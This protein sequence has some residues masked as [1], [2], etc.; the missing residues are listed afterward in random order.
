MNRYQFNYK[1]LEDYHNIKLG[2]ADKFLVKKFLLDSDDF[3]KKGQ[4]ELFVNFFREYD[5]I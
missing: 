3:K 1:V 4:L 2:V 5:F